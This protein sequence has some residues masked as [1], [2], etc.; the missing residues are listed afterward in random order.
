MKSPPKLNVG[1]VAMF[2]DVA[3]LAPRITSDLP[4]RIAAPLARVIPTNLR[5]VTLRSWFRCSKFIRHDAKRYVHENRF[6]CKAM[7]PLR[8]RI[9]TSNASSRFFPKVTMPPSCPAM[10]K[11]F[12]LRTSLTCEQAHDFVRHFRRAVS[13]GLRSCRNAIEKRRPQN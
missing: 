5:R 10:T 9:R 13:N 1:F 7:I 2:D 4:A 12:L 3:V 6:K 11:I 8:S